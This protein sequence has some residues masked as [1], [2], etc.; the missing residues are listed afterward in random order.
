MFV[1]FYDELDKIIDE[2]IIKNRKT[3]IF[4]KL[5]KIRKRIDF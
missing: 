5:E 3:I 4:V 2:D 1:G